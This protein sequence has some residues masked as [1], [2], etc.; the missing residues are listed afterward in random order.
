MGCGGSKGAEIKVATAG[1]IQVQPQE[2]PETTSPNQSDQFQQ[3]SPVTETELQQDSNGTKDGIQ[4]YPPNEGEE[5]DDNDQFNSNGM[6][7]LDLPT[8]DDDGS[9]MTSALSTR[10]APPSI[11][12]RPS[13]RGGRAFEISFEDDDIRRPPRRLQKLQGARRR[14]GELTLEQLQRKL[15]AA[16]RR[17]KEYEERILEKIVV[18]TRR[19]ADK[20]DEQTEEKSKEIE[21]KVEK[22]VDRAVENREAHLRSLREKLR[23]RDEH[24]RRVREKKQQQQ[25]QQQ[26]QASA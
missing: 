2:S 3:N 26:Q 24:S 8:D 10:S 17:K 5:N 20:R 1:T 21:G 16:E 19:P 23:A 6:E 25:Q 22:K 18:D 9:R 12:E 7:G 15:E 11:T 4:P 14:K 13:S